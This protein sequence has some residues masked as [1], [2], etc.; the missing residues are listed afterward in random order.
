MRYKRQQKA[1]VQLGNDYTSFF[2]E[3]LASHLS[4][5]SS[6]MNTMGCH[7]ISTVD[8]VAAARSVSEILPLTR[9]T[10]SLGYEL[11]TRS[12]VTRLTWYAE[13]H[14][15]ALGSR[16]VLYDLCVK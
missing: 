13:N 9:S 7:N 4:S 1:I 14:G 3:W 10:R 15:T 11:P 12:N 2:S 5:S 6:V 8:G 16:Y